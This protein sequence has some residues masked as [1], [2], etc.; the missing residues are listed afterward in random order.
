MTKPPEVELADK[1]VRR[2]MKQF[3][4]NMIE[5]QADLNEYRAYVADVKKVA[6]M[7]Y[8]PS[9]EDLQRER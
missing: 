5:M 7:P 9:E 6:L 4:T 8:V 1:Q 2:L 3:M